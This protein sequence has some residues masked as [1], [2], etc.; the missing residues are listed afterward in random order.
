MIIL[1][2][3]IFQVFNLTPEQADQ[4]RAAIQERINNRERWRDIGDEL[5]DLR[6]QGKPPFAPIQGGGS[7][8]EADDTLI[9]K[10]WGEAGDESLDWMPPDFVRFRSQKGCLCFPGCPHCTAGTCD[11]CECLFKLPSESGWDW[12]IKWRKTCGGCCGSGKIP[13]SPQTTKR[14][15]KW[16]SNHAVKPSQTHRQ[17]SKK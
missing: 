14:S 2:A 5:E 6:D 15:K 8:T 3:L 10:S 4:L 16:A 13:N 1:L 17:S 7:D 9:G 11:P 12:E